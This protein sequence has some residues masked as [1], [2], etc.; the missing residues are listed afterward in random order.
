MF[1]SRSGAY[2][3]LARVTL[4][5]NHATSDEERAK[6]DAMYNMAKKYLEEVEKCVEE[7]IRKRIRAEKRREHGLN[8]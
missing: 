1:L 7:S 8:L 4:E 2:D 3:A 5:W 6:A